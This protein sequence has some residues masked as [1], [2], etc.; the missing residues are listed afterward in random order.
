MHRIGRCD[1][2]TKRGIKLNRRP[3]PRY[4]IVPS[5]II[6]SPS[7][8]HVYSLVN[9]GRSHLFSMQ[10]P[11]RPAPKSTSSDL[12]PGSINNDGSR[13]EGGGGYDD[14]DHM[15]IVFDQIR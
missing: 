3:S 10:R 5:I 12:Q 14:Y 7:L 6:T 9:E 2:R 1:Q 15:I 13:N 4:R 8:F 11:Q